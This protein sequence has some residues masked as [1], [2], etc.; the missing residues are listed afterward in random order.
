MMLFS[1]ERTQQYPGFTL[2]SLAIGQWA[3]NVYGCIWWLGILNLSGKI[4]WENSFIKKQTWKKLIGQ[5]IP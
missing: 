3:G 4:E 1:L 5:D 2:I